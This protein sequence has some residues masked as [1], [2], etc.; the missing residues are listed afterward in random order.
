MTDFIFTWS[1]ATPYRTRPYGA[2]EPV[3]HVDADRLAGGQQ[4]G[5]GVQP[6][7]ARSDHRDPGLSLLHVVISCGGGGVSRVEENRAA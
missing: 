4:R 5:G 7:R 2:G 1:G 6:G 3:E